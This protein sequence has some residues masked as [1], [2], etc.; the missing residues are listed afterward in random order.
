MLGYVLTPVTR[1]C[2][3]A[4]VAVAAAVLLTGCARMNSA[5][6]QQWLVVQFNT[7][8]KM[9]VARQ[10]MSACSHL[11]GVRL[12][13][14]SPDAAQSGMVG[15]A[16]YNTSRASTADMARLTECLQKFPSVQGVTVDEAGGY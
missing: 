9:A 13:G 11:P 8:T 1:A 12:G 3:G 16:R 7:G 2:R 15:S 10:V 5:L 14:V 6:G 4:C